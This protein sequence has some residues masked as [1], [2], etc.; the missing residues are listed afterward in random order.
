MTNSKLL[1]TVLIAATTLL[2]LV[3]CTS[4]NKDRWYTDTVIVHEMSD[5]D[6]LNVV[7]SSS[8]SATYI[9]YNIFMYLLDVN[10]EELTINPSLAKER[11]TVVELDTGEYAGGLRIDYEIR[12]EAVWDNGKPVTGHDV[13]FTLKAIKNPNVDAEHLR[14]Y[15]DFIKHME[16]DEQN[17]KKF[18]LY[19]K[20]PYFAAEFSSG[21]I[22]Y[23]A[24][25]Y[26]YDPKGLMKGYTLKELSDPDKVSELK[27]DP[28]MVEFGEEM[29]SEK[30]QR[31]K[32]FVVGCGPYEFVEWQTGQR[33][34][35]KKKENWWGERLASE[36]L[37]FKA[38]PETIQ[39]EI[40]ND[41]ATVA[42]TIRNHGVDVSRSLKAKDYASFKGNDRINE[43]YNMPSPVQLSYTY[44]GIHTRDPKLEDKRVRQA[45]SH[46]VDREQIISV[47]MYDLAEPTNSPIHPTKPY[48]NEAI[49]G[50]DFNLEQAKALLDEAGWKDT[51]GDGVRDKVIN[52]RKTPLELSIK[53]NQ[54]NA[55]RENTA[56]FF[57]EN[58]EK[59]GIKVNVEVR[60]WT[61]YLEEVKN[62]NFEL[63]VLGWVQ[64]PIM[65]DPKQIWHTQSYNGGSN[66]AGFGN[67]YSDKLIEDIRREMDTEK[68][69]AMFKEFQQIVHDEAPYIFL[70]TPYNRLLISK[71][72]EDPQSYV[73]RPGYT[74]REFKVRQPE[75]EQ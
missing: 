25:E 38:L 30:F 35:L 23:I 11:P 56:I 53:Y 33:I 66:Y 29:N 7:T 71:R 72:F 8:A 60:E 70:Y 42:N 43:L 17:P 32:G 41:P 63:C 10:K 69:Y 61:V 1:T 62:H 2:L 24:P 46:I 52:G 51:D 18:T 47:L 57:K 34:L 65:D 59:V 75:P 49:E 44:I 5:P 12:E 9:K 68:R 22:A 28:K 31:E 39:Y 14:P 13:L 55:A 15:V 37:N 6:K 19:S 48:Y 54:G 67:A 4:E 40:I 26:I 50:Y 58:A 16:I 73:A 36:A 27:S 21:G 3:G 64:G 45:L 20:E 74:E